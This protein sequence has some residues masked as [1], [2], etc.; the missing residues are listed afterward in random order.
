MQNKTFCLGPL[1]TN[2]YVVT[3]QG[4]SAVIDPGD[5]TEEFICYLQSLEN[6]KY[7]LLTHCHCDHVSA[8]HKIRQLFGAKIAIHSAD[9]PF[10]NN[11][12]GNLADRMGGL[13]TMDTFPQADI[14]LNDGDVLA[15]GESKMQVIHTPGHT[16][17]GVCFLVEDIL[18]TGDTLMKGTMGRFDFPGGDRNVLFDSLRKL[19]NLPSQYAVYP[20]HGEPTTLQN[21]LKYNPYLL[22]LE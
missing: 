6:I 13:Y 16:L 5:T 7:I 10:W 17:G 9:A 21:E 2:A 12:Q 3:C 8:A 4:Q 22:M 14:I 18:F 20:G 19:K 1:G 15:L 11:P